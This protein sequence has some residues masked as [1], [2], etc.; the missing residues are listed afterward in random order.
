MKTKCLF[1]IISIYINL[2]L[3]SQEILLK[4]F[5]FTKNDKNEW[6]DININKSLIKIDSNNNISRIFEIDVPEEGEYYLSAWLMAAEINNEY[7]QYE[8]QINNKPIKNK[9]KPQKNNWQK[10]ELI[11]TELKPMTIFLNKGHN[12]I[13][14]ISSAP[15]VPQVEFI[16]L[17]KNR[18]KIKFTDQAYND[19]ITSIKT[20]IKER[21]KNPIVYK[22]SL[23]LKAMLPNPEGNYYHQIKVPFSYTFYTNYVPSGY[24]FPQ[25]VIFT[26]NA[27]DG[28]EHVL[29]V[30]SYSNP[31]NYSWA[32]LSNSNGVAYLRINITRPDLYFIRIRAYR[33]NTH[34][35][36][37]LMISPGAITY[38][39]CPVSGNGF[40][41]VH[42]T[43]T[44]YNYFTC[45]L[46]G[47]SYLWIED[48]S[49]MP[50]KI[51]AYNDDYSGGG[52]DF[53]WGLASRVKKDFSVRI[54]AALVS[55]YSSYNPTGT[56]DLYIMCQNSTIMSYFPNLKADDAIQSAPASNNYNCASWGGGMI[57]RGRYFW[58]SNPPNS[59]NLSTNWYVAGNFWQSWDNFFGNNPLRYT[60]APTYTRTGANSSN[61]EVAMWYNSTSYQ[62][63]HFSVVK[64]ANDQPHG[65]DW[66]S[67][68]GGLMRT[69][70]PR[71]ALNDNSYY[72]YGS[73]SL[74]Y[75]RVNPSLK[76]YS[77]KESIELG[78]TVLP[79]VT[80]NMDE[81]EL[82]QDLK[83]NISQED[84]ALF[85]Q[86]MKL[87]VDKANTPELIKQSNPF[88][89]Y[90]TSEFK[91]ILD[92]CKKMG[93]VLWPLLFEKIFDDNNPDARDLSILLI[94][95]TTPEYASLMEKV[96]EE[97]INNNYTPEGAYIA[98]SPIANTKNYVKKLLAVK[99]GETSTSVKQPM[100]NDNYNLFSV[101][102]NPFKYQTTLEFNVA[103]NNSVVSLK[104]L[105]INGKLL[106]TVIIN[107]KY[108][109]G[110]WQVQWLAGNYKPGLYL[111]NLTINGKTF[112][113]RFFIE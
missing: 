86:K 89:L 68:P 24:I 11:D 101:F 64:P 94:N 104:V 37:D 109:A 18:K 56:C 67:K 7:K 78:L 32:A 48:D 40:R 73:I 111:F 57:D 66:E 69:F 102:P 10:V 47:D 81:E 31:E 112:N 77:L 84:I 80:L 35:L 91:D 72:G 17:S 23:F 38:R 55:A 19:Y 75:R 100:D 41:Y 8:I 59:N 107:Q 13:A 4:N 2:Q 15:E 103:E 54:G 90:E 21:Q 49:G 88:F 29:E 51:R 83:A 3:F 110:N 5:N 12:R 99:V 70:H 87:L 53:S 63:T 60:G 42:E 108:D 33:Q 98:P 22:D 25:Q 95:E 74:Y 36:V 93:N 16:C 79:E 50:G 45:K 97:W 14:F 58:A 46:S 52:G 20:E 62:Y 34:G 85:N 6:G 96:K 105:D 82:V 28:Y 39:N 71:D 27:A 30:F 106:E 61:G 43:P 26:T 44:T 1:I 92:F 113:R 9:I 76:S 65:Y